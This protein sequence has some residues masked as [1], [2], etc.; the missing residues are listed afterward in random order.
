MTVIDTHHHFLPPR[1]VEEVG[2]AAIASLLVSGRVPEWSVTGSLEAMNRSG[3]T[4]AVL[5]LSS[6]ATG[7]LTS[8]KR[9]DLARY[10]NE[11]AAKIMQDHPKRFGSFATLP[12]PDIDASLRELNYCFDNLSATGVCLLSNYAGRY[13][14]DA[15]FAPVFEELNR[16]GTIVFV[17]PAMPEPQASTVGLPAASL[18]FPFDTTRTIASLLFSGALARYNKIRFIFAHAGGVVPFLAGRLA[19]L[20][21]QEKFRRRVPDGV[22]TELKRL[23]FDTALSVDPY[24]LP[25]LLRFAVPDRILFGSD[26][27]HAGSSIIDLALNSL[28]SREISPQVLM[29]IEQGNAAR[30]LGG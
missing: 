25:G 20:E 14:G 5:S 18:E 30:I 22:L 26:F 12:L 11:Y 13:L 27:P 17:H 24:T 28:R 16:R 9:S 19:R 7:E 8:T 1:Y 29:A 3:V 4:L 21:S 23:H 10:C 6:P 2:E 15:Y